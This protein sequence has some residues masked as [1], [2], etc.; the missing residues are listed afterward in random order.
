MINSDIQGWIVEYPKGQMWKTPSGKFFWGT[1]AAAK[2]AFSCHDYYWLP[3]EFASLG[4]YDKKKKTEE[5]KKNYARF[6]RVT[7]KAVEE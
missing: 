6:I 3:K 4:Y 2:N 5:Y 7:L 1:S